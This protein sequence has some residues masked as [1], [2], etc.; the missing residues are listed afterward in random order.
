MNAEFRRSNYEFFSHVRLYVSIRYP[1]LKRGELGG[2]GRA[3]GEV[4]ERQIGAN[5]QAVTVKAKPRGLEFKKD[6]KTILV[7]LFYYI[8]CLF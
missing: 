1:A 4:G 2:E 5:F 8:Q 7:T 3:V 6:L